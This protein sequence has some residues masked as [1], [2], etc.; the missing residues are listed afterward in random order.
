M[1]VWKH[2]LRN[3]IALLAVAAFAIAAVPAGAQRPAESTDDSLLPGAMDDWRG[4]RPGK[5]MRGD[6]PG[7]RGARGGFGAPPPPLW[8]RFSD[9]EREQVMGFVAEHFPFAGRELESLR[10]RSPRR[11][12][13]RMAHMAPEMLRLM[14]AV[15]EDPKKG[16]LLIDER[17][18]EMEIR[19]RAM[20][21]RL[22][23]DPEEKVQ[24]EAELRKLV[25]KMFDLKLARRNYELEEL[26]ARI[27]QVR[28]SIEQM[29][30]SREEI[31][32]K[33]FNELLDRIE[34]GE[35]GPPHGR[36]GPPPPGAFG[37]PLEERD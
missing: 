12:E 20:R 22:T 1:V 10:E 3:R 18:T 36:G 31:V 27:G 9:Q 35:D 29:R 19:L 4:D 15:H 37:Q 28:G 17:R 14:E 13:R 11:F 33:H 8:E 6:R 26:A 21:Y 2:S 34:S 5:R 24:V 32:E 7:R 25:E 30:E 23:T 16:Q